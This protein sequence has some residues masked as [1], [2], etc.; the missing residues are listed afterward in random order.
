[1]SDRITSWSGK[2]RMGLRVIAPGPGIGGN[3]RVLYQS[4]QI[5]APA[6]I[7]AAGR[8]LPYGTHFTS[9]KLHFNLPFK[10]SKRGV[11]NCREGG[12]KA[13]GGRRAAAHLDSAAGRSYCR[14]ALP[15][16]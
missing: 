10:I 9:S 13:A 3:A 14:I 6:S 7:L 4:P 16:I 5:E 11:K 2:P 1:M 15:C 12:A 8:L